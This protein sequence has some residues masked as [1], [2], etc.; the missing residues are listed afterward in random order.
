MKS[1][2]LGIICLAILA[3]VAL[4]TSSAW[5]GKVHMQNCTDVKIKVRSYRSN[6]SKKNAPAK[7]KFIRNKGHKATVSCSTKRCDIH[8]IVVR[9]GSPNLTYKKG[10]SKGDLSFV[11]FRK[12]GHIDY[13]FEKGHKCNK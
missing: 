4:D 10:Q 12:N 8:A 3:F 6:D 9:P 11:Q 7:E 2:H 5:A 1:T 13:K